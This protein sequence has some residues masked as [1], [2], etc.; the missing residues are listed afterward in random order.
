[1]KPTMNRSRFIGDCLVKIMPRSPSWHDGGKVPPRIFEAKDS[2]AGAT[3]SARERAP[4]LGSLQKIVQGAQDVW[5]AQH[6]ASGHRVSEISDSNA[7][8]MIEHD[9]LG[10]VTSALDGWS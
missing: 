6:T 5:E 2:R 3:A 1:M 9:P 4:T 7:T 10:R 8:W